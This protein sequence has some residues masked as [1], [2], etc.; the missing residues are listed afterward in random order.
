MDLALVVSAASLVG[1][2][3]ESAGLQRGSVRSVRKPGWRPI[4]LNKRERKPVSLS[5]PVTVFFNVVTNQKAW[6]TG[7]LAWLT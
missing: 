7:F 3:R 1:A 6:L 4:R 2:S 5:K